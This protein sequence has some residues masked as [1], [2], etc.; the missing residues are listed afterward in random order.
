[1]LLASIACAMTAMQQRQLWQVLLH[2]W[3]ACSHDDLW[4]DDPSSSQVSK[5]TVPVVNS[6][7]L[8]F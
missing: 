6:G 2:S 3:S 5:L 4:R 1:M 7:E 8:V